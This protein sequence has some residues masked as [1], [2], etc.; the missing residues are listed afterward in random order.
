[1]ITTI[2]LLTATAL[3]LLLAGWAYN[4]RFKW[5]KPVFVLGVFAAVGLLLVASTSCAVPADPAP[6][7]RSDA[8][9]TQRDTS[10]SFSQGA[11]QIQK[12]LQD[13]KTNSIRA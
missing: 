5:S 7:E 12:I 6:S 8:T 9:A 4:A 10:G 2:F 11:A 3:V 13:Y 1:M